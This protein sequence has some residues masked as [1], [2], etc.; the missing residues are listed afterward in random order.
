MGDF[1]SGPEQF[2]S[3]IWT[4]PGFHLQC[5]RPDWMHMCCLRVL[6]YLIGDCLWECFVALG[7]VFTNSRRACNRLEN[8]IEM[9]AKRL[10]I[11]KPLHSLTITM[12]RP[13]ATGKPKFKGKAAVNRH[14]LPILHEMLLKCFPLDTEHQKARCHCV[15]AMHEA[16]REMEAWD[17]QTYPS[18]LGDCARRCL[19]LWAA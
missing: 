19:I 18:R 12:I 11:E 7:G 4:I 5:I 8:I 1:Y 15:G 13:Q 16:Y 10:D 17:P 14:L 9:I 3:R 2:I 6:Q